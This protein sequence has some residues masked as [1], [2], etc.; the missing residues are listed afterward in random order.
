[1]KTIINEEIRNS[2]AEVLEILRY[3][4][5]DEYN[6]IPSKEIEVLKIN[7]NKEHKFNYDPSKSLNEQKVLKRTKMIIAVFFCEYWADDEQRKKIFAHDNEY[8]RQQEL[9]KNKKY[10]PDNIFQKKDKEENNI[11]KEINLIKY[12]ESILKRLFNKIKNFFISNK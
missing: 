2:Y 1:M 7:A 8:D 3:L 12:N 4:D 6:K 11:S 5:K 9:E 10:N